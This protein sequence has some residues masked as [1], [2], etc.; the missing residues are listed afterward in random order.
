MTG[1]FEWDDRKAA[2]NVRKHGVTFL[3]AT[4]AFADMFAVFDLEDSGDY[5]EERWTL[6]GA[7]SGGLLT[8]IYTERGENIR[9]IS[10]RRAERYEREHYYK[11]NSEGR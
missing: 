3:Q 4:K 7:V 6:I 1:Q 11:S 10:A 5:G 2:E 9:I 8:V